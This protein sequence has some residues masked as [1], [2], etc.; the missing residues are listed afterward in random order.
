M[1]RLPEEFTLEIYRPARYGG[2]ARVSTSSIFPINVARGMP[3]PTGGRG[4]QPFFRIL[5]PAAD[6]HGIPPDGYPPGTAVLSPS[7]GPLHPPPSPSLLLTVVSGVTGPSRPK[8][9]DDFTWR[10]KKRKK[11]VKNRSFR[12]ELTAGCSRRAGTKGKS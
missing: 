1:C 10:C 12:S 7:R 11:K 5:T 8:N 2:I 3:A 4:P 6:E 9:R